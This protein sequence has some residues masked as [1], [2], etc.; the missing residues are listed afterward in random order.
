MAA[1]VT[2]ENFDQL[3]PV[4]PNLT[5]FCSENTDATILTNVVSAFSQIAE[6]LAH[7]PDHLLQVD[8]F[9]FVNKAI[10]LACR[11]PSVIEPRVSSMLLHTAAIICDNCPSV[12]TKLIESEQHRL[13]IDYLEDN[14]SSSEFS[15]EGNETLSS[16]SILET[17]RMNQTLTGATGA[18]F[19]L[20]K[21][22]LLDIVTLFAAL[23][24]ALPHDNMFAN[25]CNQMFSS[26]ASVCWQFQANTGWENYSPSTIKRLEQAYMDGKVHVEMIIN[27]NQY[28]VRL[29]DM[30]QMSV[31]HHSHRE[32]RR[33]IIENK[34]PQ[35][36]NKMELILFLREHS[37]VVDFIAEATF[38]ILYSMYQA[39]ASRQL[40]VA[41]LDCFNR[42]V[43]FASEEQLRKWLVSVP[44][45]TFLAEMVNSQEHTI[46]IGALSVAQMLMQ[47]LPGVFDVYF[48]RKGLTQA[49][50]ALCA[51]EPPVVELKKPAPRAASQRGLSAMLRRSRRSRQSEE[52]ASA[53]PEPE[54]EP[55]STVPTTAEEICT[56][57]RHLSST[58]LKA[59][60]A[61]RVYE[62]A[63]QVGTSCFPSA[64]DKSDQDHEAYTFL[65]YSDVIVLFCLLEFVFLSCKSY[66][67]SPVT[68]VYSFAIG[69]FKG[70]QT[71]WTMHHLQRPLR[72][73]LEGLLS[74]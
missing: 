55:E 10:D 43:M 29:P 44:V 73:V 66:F 39:S 47:K 11:L 71:R 74:G 16:T 6:C 9:G 46:K 38:G 40:R 34:L 22:H 19:T 53:P 27:G 52:A 1:H 70:L 65:R 24:P 18:A 54:P 15:G 21:Q 41:F 4:L 37:D 72:N 26:P 56:A 14:R 62:C 28:V 35:T 25:F 17:S 58:D 50:V 61:R 32:V 8:Q 42:L 59:F 20:G 13:L 3:A 60:T 63:L 30:I 69:S 23:L 7:T 49:I 5:Q 51:K 31:K 67:L 2:T 33:Q 12:A 64:M 45:S 48:R 36:H 68:L 57:I